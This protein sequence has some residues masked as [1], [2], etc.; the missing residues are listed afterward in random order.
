M[1]MLVP[2]L[3]LNQLYY[4]CGYGGE[5]ENSLRLFVILREK[6][7]AFLILRSREYEWP[8]SSFRSFTAVSDDIR[9][10]WA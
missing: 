2:S 6:P 5:N 4:R 10:F 3:S 8:A 7:R 1:F 9:P